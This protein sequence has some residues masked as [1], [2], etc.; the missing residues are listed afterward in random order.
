METLPPTTYSRIPSQ[1]QAST[2]YFQASPYLN[3]QLPAIHYQPP[4]QWLVTNL[5]SPQECR[6]PYEL[7]K[8]ELTRR[9]SKWL[10]GIESAMFQNP[11]PRTRKSRAYK[12][13]SRPI[14]SSR[15]T[16]DSSSRRLSSAPAH[17]TASGLHGDQRKIRG[18]HDRNILT[19]IPSLPT[20]L[21]ALPGQVLFGNCDPPLFSIRDLDDLPDPLNN[22]MVRPPHNFDPDSAADDN[23][24][25]P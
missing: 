6:D 17:D 13:Y 23:N 24:S 5:V 15:T 2:P 22:P 12:P 8:A 19:S 1:L 21:P 16:S 11:G 20:L 14:P 9:V 18:C 10:L 3:I 4:K 25:T 7:S